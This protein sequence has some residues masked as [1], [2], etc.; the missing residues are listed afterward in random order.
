[1]IFGKL[2]KKFKGTSSKDTGHG[3]D[4][5]LISA[6]F[7]LLIVGLIVLFSASS[8]ISY[9]KFAVTYHYAGRQLVYVLFSLI[10]FFL[11]SKI[12]YLWWRKIAS[13][14]L[15]LSVVLLVLVFVPGLKAEYGTSQ[16]WINIFGVSLQPSELVKITFLIYL[17][18]WMEA[19]KS[20]ISSLS[21][22]V[23]PFLL[24]LAVISGLM[25]A[26][27][28]MGSLFIII[29]SAMAAFFVGGEK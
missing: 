23:L 12:N 10:I 16:S 11:V 19:K 29:A 27:P 4:K 26:Q 22:G 2:V 13:F 15:F 24:T 18:S 3:A 9:Q 17:A 28:D 1:M 5:S 21:G 25:L 8:A 6:I 7:L 20:I 14:L